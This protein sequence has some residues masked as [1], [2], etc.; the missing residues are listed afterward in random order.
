MGRPTVDYSL[1]LVTGRELL[2]PG[3]VCRAMSTYPDRSV[4]PRRPPAIRRC[5]HPPSLVVLGASVDE[6]CWAAPVTSSGG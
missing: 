1:Y 3:K 5:P 2:P 6:R 4:Q